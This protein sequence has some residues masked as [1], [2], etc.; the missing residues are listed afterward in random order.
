MTALFGVALMGCT[1]QVVGPDHFEAA[2]SIGGSHAAP[3]RPRHIVGRPYY[4]DGKLI[5]PRHQPDYSAIGQA[6]WFGPSEN[7]RRTAN[8]EL[9]D[10]SN[11]FAAHPS[12]P[13]PSYVSVENLSNGR[14]LTVRVNDRNPIEQRRIIGLSIRA[15]ELLGLHKDR[16]AR[17][18]VRYLSPAPIEYIGRNHG[19]S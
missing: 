6:S 11:L 17:V 7:G 10:S 18:H 15:A 12:L 5:R 14:K 3:Q 9:V 16:N 1:T 4:R 19:Q 2:N 13:L 8:G